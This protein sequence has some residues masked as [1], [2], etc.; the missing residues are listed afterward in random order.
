LD[1][2]FPELVAHRLR[3]FLWVGDIVL[4]DDA[5]RLR[6]ALER[7]QHLASIQRAEDLLRARREALVR[8]DERTGRLLARERQYPRGF[9]PP[10]LRAHEQDIQRVNARFWAAG[11]PLPFP[12]AT[13]ASIPLT[14]IDTALVTLRHAG[15]LSEGSEWSL[16]AESAPEVSRLVRKPLERMVEQDLDR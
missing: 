15:F 6:V 8:K 1:I 16:R 10:S 4:P 9:V 11:A 13:L 3:P 12:T 5:R 14:A 7:C 2:T